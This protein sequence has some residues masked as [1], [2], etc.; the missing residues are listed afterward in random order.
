M[1]LAGYEPTTAKSERPQTHG[2]NSETTG[3][4]FGFYY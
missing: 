3:I 2:L 4:G 1:P